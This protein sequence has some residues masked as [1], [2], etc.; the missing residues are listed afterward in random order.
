MRNMEASS[1]GGETNPYE[2]NQWLR[3]FEVGNENEPDLTD[4]DS[5]I[6]WLTMGE[7]VEKEKTHE[8][9]IS[10]IGRIITTISE[11]I[12]KRKQAKKKA[13]QRKSAESAKEV[14]PNPDRTAFIDKYLNSIPAEDAEK[15]YGVYSTS[16]MELEKNERPPKGKLDVLNAIM[17]R[18]TPENTDEGDRL[19][20]ELINLHKE[21]FIEKHLNTTF[22]CPSTGQ[23]LS[24][25]DAQ[26]LYD[27][28]SYHIAYM[29][30]KER[31]ES[32][33]GILFE[34]EYMLETKLEGMN[35]ADDEEARADV[36]RLLEQ[37]RDLGARASI[38]QYVKDAESL[39]YFGSNKALD[40]YIT[41]TILD[42]GYH[43]KGDDKD[44]GALKVERTLGIIEELGEDQPIEKVWD[45]ITNDGKEGAIDWDAVKRFAPR[46]R[47]YAL[48]NYDK[49]RNE[50]SEFLEERDACQK[51][52]DALSGLLAL[53][54]ERDQKRAANIAE[55]SSEMMDI[56][57]RIAEYLA[58]AK[59]DGI[60]TDDDNNSSEKLRYKI[61]K[62]EELHSSVDKK[63]SAYEQMFGRSEK[64]FA[65]DIL[66]LRD[67]ESHPRVREIVRFLY[68]TYARDPKGVAAD[69]ADSSSVEAHISCLDHMI[70]DMNSQISEIS[71]LYDEERT[72]GDVAWYQLDK[73]GQRFYSKKPNYGMLMSSGGTK[74]LSPE[75]TILKKST[76]YAVD[77]VDIIGQWK[78]IYSEDGRLV[79]AQARNIPDKIEDYDNQSALLN[80]AEKILS[81]VRKSLSPEPSE[82]LEFPER[83]E[84][85]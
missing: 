35:D 83:S 62:E 33:T 18:F 52:I 28:Y 21:A 66:K 13:K 39:D 76:E 30:P 63:M 29:D 78:L 10:R 70:S 38:H 24:A 50:M 6:D 23:K 1:G 71:N 84:A 19:S 79:E 77:N 55:D 58:K 43:G 31:P 32:T 73:D 40:R 47:G 7:D 34:M 3:Y 64:E 80:A 26:R 81:E 82:F 11:G 72:Y 46:G 65:R 54:E 36:R 67:Y 75:E 37:V 45:I 5:D 61:S 68:E 48:Y 42:E 60:L 49:S 53:K 74:G 14:D 22:E 2:E 12:Q 41:H 15:L 17:S 57:N 20:D 8:S 4:I 16:V 44:G 25:E 59:E 51:R 85:A 69:Y 27:D 9:I 56:K